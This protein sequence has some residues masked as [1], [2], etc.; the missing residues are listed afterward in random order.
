MHRLHGE[1]EVTNAESEAWELT[2][3]MAVA[4]SWIFVPACTPVNSEEGVLLRR[5]I[6]MSFAWVADGHDIVIVYYYWV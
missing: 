6:T 3:T 1:L 4:L 2:T 5:R